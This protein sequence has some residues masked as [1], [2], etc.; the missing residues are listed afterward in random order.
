MK[1][2]LLSSL[3]LSTLT[4]LNGCGSSVEDLS[5]HS[6]PIMGAPNKGV[7]INRVD[8]LEYTRTFAPVAQLTTKDST[9][10]YRT[11]EP[12]MFH[13]GNLE[14]GEA[15]GLAILTPKEIVS[16]KNLELNTSINSNEVNNRVRVLMSL[17]DDNNTANGI[18]INYATRVA[19]KKWS[20]PDYNLAESAFTN[21]LKSSTGH[22]FDTKLITTK[23]EAKKQFADELRC[24]YSGAY[25]GQYI[26]Q[27]GAKSG[28]VGVMIQSSNTVDPHSSLGTIVALGDGQDLN[29][30]GIAKEYLFAR[31]THNMDTGSYIFNETG[32][33]NT[34]SG[35]IVPSTQV[36][37]G[38]G[39]SLDYNNVVGSFEQ[40]NPNTNKIE[41]GSYKASRVGNADNSSYRYTGFGYDNNGSDE[42]TSS[43]PILGLFTFDIEKNGTVV[44]LIHDARNNLEPAI[45][46]E[47]DFNASVDNITMSLT[48]PN[49][50]GTFLIKGTLVFDGTVNLDWFDANG[51]TKYG[52]IAGVGCQL[53]PHN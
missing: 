2:T 14:L 51:T 42:N 30:D 46:G 9:Y 43:D 35:S 25:S 10:D 1:F 4:L 21:E 37:K 15:L 27:N 31:G 52:Y 28:F 53:Q 7:F 39:R 23:A 6:E 32:E 20:T 22:Y 44:G 50:G 17:D 24:I 48:Y 19:A 49:N 16:Y 11:G 34:T 33:F 18:Q 5:L 29:G 47:V 36:I 3:V 45:K 38:D 12:I 26:L 8:G 13:I 40:K 41:V